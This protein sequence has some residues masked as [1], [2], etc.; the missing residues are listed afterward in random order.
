M[1]LRALLA[2]VSVVAATMAALGSGSQ[3]A[4]VQYG[5]RRLRSPIL[6]KPQK[7]AQ[8]VDHLLEDAC[9]D[10]A[11]R[12]LV[13]CLPRRQVVGHVSPRGAGAHDPPQPVEYLAQVVGALGS[14]LPDKREVRGDKR[15]L[16]V[17]NVAWVWF[18]CSHAQMLTFPN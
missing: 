15:P 2:L 12:L 3:R 6:R 7:H 14:V 1:H 11:L 8:I 18:S 4:R 10:P 13:D 9:L 5:R 16:L 17:G